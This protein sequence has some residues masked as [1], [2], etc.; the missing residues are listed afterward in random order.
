MYI[1]CYIIFFL[2]SCNFFVMC[3]DITT[4]YK[5]VPVLVTG[6]A[7]FIGSHLV[8]A[9]VSHGAYV[10]ILD[11]LSTGSRDNIKHVDRHLTFIEGSIT[12]VETC[13]KAAENKK[14]IFHL[15]AFISVPG[16]INDP[17]KCHINND[18]G[19]L[20]V[21]EAARRNNVERVI[22]S[23]SCAVYGAPKQVICAENDTCE[24]ESPYGYSKYIAEQ[25][26]KEYAKCYGINTVILRYFNVYG[27]RQNPHGAYAAVI[28]K[29]TELMK[30]NQPVVIF[31]DGTQTRDF[32]TVSDII[33]ANLLFG[34]YAEISKVRGEIFNI[35]TGESI[36]LLGI[37]DALKKQFPHYQ[38]VPVFVKERKGDVKHIAADIT[39]YR[40]F[41]KELIFN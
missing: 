7:G 17:Y 20:N 22:F 12:D 41:S 32:V 27:N 10:T 30:K 37:F 21:L 36:T 33:Q 25:Y 35:A 6:G 14:I 8:D 23:S 19:T 18:V 15:A 9:L 2:I 24:P 3:T 40:L 34:S 28:A 31:G 16:S 29:F 4:F 26:M 13:I 38:H 1:R 39:K 11:D 5:D